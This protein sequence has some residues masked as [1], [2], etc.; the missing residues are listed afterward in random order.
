MNTEAA[1]PMTPTEAKI[2]PLI[3]YLATLAL[4]VLLAS[5]PAVTRFTVT[6]TLTPFDLMA[7]RCAIGGLVL[8]PYLA[9]QWRKL[10]SKLL[11]VGFV[12]SFFQGWGMHLTTIIGLQYAPAAHAS[13]LGPGFIPVWVALWGW[14]IYRNRITRIQFGGLALISLGAVVLLLAST[15]A[16][17]STETIVGDV[18]FLAASCMG[19]VY[20]VY[21]QKNRTPPILGAALIAVYSALVTI[22]WYLFAYNESRILVAPLW[23]VFLQMIYQG[24]G[25]G[26]LFLLLLN[27]VV[28]RL[29]SQRFSIMGAC[30][31]VL[32]LLFGKWIAGDGISLMECV[33]IAIISSGVL[34]GAF[35]RGESAR[36]GVGIAPRA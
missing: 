26:A 24:L 19:A 1:Q 32:A 3:T 10:P 36:L 17:F 35:Y 30:V 12:L 34:Y 25:V 6:K 7:M 28:V 8:L 4:I 13:A 31:P 15:G 33:A 16:A 11:W 20:L 29:G 22:P 27:Y 9:S 21:I 23:E 5:S 14:L 18:F 2:D